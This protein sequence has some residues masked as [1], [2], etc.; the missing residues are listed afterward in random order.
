MAKK[1]AIKRD[2]SQPQEVSE[3]ELAFPANVSRLM[4]EY[5]DIPEE[6]SMYSG[7]SIF[8]K[9]QSKW[10]FEGLQPEDIPPAKAGIDQTKALNHL[11]CIQR[12]Y[13]PSHQHKCAAVSYLMSLW[14]E[15]PKE[16][17]P[18]KF[19]NLMKS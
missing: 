11:T 13:E 17:R 10:F 3:V 8:C 19:K 2:F 15:E 7:T 9:L 6:F 14:F 4:P 18:I 12:S 16:V 1:P 5:K